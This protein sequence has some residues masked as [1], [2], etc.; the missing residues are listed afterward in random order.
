M[1]L[2]PPAGC[3]CL[4]SQLVSPLPVSCSQLT[5]QPLSGTLSNHVHPHPV[6]LNHRLFLS[7]AG[8]ANTTD[9]HS[10]KCNHQLMKSISFLQILW[11]FPSLRSSTYLKTW[12]GC[13]FPH[14][15]DAHPLSQRLLLGLASTP[16]ASFL[17]MHAPEGSRPRPKSLHS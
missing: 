10:T 8:E 14:D 9:T 15:W 16:N 5:V 3:L 13:L 6:T 11:I 2:K 1:D 12:G 7:E 17:L 4:T